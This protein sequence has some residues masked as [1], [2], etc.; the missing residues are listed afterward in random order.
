[1][2]L[3]DARFTES[4][5]VC[6]EEIIEVLKKYNLIDKYGI[7]LLHDHFPIHLDEVLLETTLSEDK[8]IQ[9]R[10]IKR[11]DA[12]NVN[13]FET[14]WYFDKDTNNIICSQISERK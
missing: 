4:D 7:G 8:T 13:H 3:E 2:L 1:M 5:K 10:T 14:A 6:F 9:T 12:K 11:E